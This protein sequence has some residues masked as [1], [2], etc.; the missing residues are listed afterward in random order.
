MKTNH[1]TTSRIAAVA[2]VITAAINGVHAALPPPLPAANPFVSQIVEISPAQAMAG[3]T[4]TVRVAPTALMTFVAQRNQ[5]LN[6][7]ALRPLNLTPLFAAQPPK[8]FFP[9]S[10]GFQ[11]IPGTSMTS[12]GDNRYSVV[13]PAAGR[14]G[15][16]RFETSAGS[17]YS[18][19][20]F[21]RVNAGYSFVNLSQ[22]N[23]VSVKVDG[24]ERLAGQSI[25]ATLPTNPNVFVAD[26][27]TTPGNHSLTVTIGR[28]VNQPVIVFGPFTANATVPTNVIEVGIM[29]AGDYLTASPNAAVSGNNITASWQTLIVNANGALSVNGFDFTRN[30]NTGVTTWVNWFGDRPNVVA[31]GNVS[32][33]AN[34]PLNP[35]SVTLQLRRPNGALYTSAVVNLLNKTFIPADGNSYE[36]Q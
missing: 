9:D 35:T 36:L 24:V 31:T 23:V 11:W 27:G 28:S 16:L 3:Q 32:E 18:T 8:I 13:V 4:I 15:K 12:L 30:V 34:W 22:F 20:D 17:S 2:A 14:S 7:A 33:P 1:K 10:L 19:V 26:V 5:Q 6:L 29:A 21:T 25:P